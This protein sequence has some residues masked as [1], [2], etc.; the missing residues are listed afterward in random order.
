MALTLSD[1]RERRQIAYESELDDLALLTQEARLCV[2]RAIMHRTINTGQPRF[3]VFKDFRGVFYCEPVD[4][5]LEVFVRYTWGRRAE[6][7]WRGKITM[8]AQGPDRHT[9]CCHIDRDTRERGPIPGGKYVYNP[10]IVYLQENYWG[11]VIVWRFIDDHETGRKLQQRLHELTPEGNGMVSAIADTKGLNRRDNKAKPRDY[12][13]FEQRLR[14]EMDHQ[15]AASL[16]VLEYIQ[17]WEPDKN[18]NLNH[19]KG[20]HHSAS[21]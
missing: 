5:F 8:P 12:G 14:Q 19:Y 10:H 3:A 15:A 16:Q 21:H 1:M 18:Y 7:N 13:L 17:S 2:H 11:P 4:E 6:R 9:S 20:L